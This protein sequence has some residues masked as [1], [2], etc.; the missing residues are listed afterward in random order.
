MLAFF[1]VM[2]ISILLDGRHLRVGNQLLFPILFIAYCVVSLLWSYNQTVAYRQ[3]ITQLQLILLLIFT[4]M[5]VMKNAEI[6]DYLDAVYIAGWGMVVHAI[7]RYGGL[8]NYIKIMEEGIRMGDEITNQNVFGLV[9]SNAALAAA[10]YLVFRKRKL[11]L[12][13]IAVF[14]FFALSSGSK[15][16]ALL[17]VLGILAIVAV[18]NGIKRIYKT[19]IAGV[20]VLIAASYVLQ[21]PYFETINV[22]LEEYFSGELNTSDEIRQEL[23]N[24]GVKLFQ[25]KPFFGYGLDN[26]YL[27]SP[28]GTY[29]HNNFIEVL[30]SGGV[31]GFVLYYSMYVVPLCKMFLGKFKKFAWQNKEYLMLLILVVMELVFSYGMVQLYDKNSYILLGVALASA[32]KLGLICQKETLGNPQEN[33]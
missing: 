33:K 22:R 10:Y 4:Y 26:Y 6:K 25:K 13:S 30:V 16:A 31:V 1:A 21:L 9:F 3:L 2:A 14:T 8:E 24:V 12:I 7:I 27:F 5:A 15:K 19:V 11:D 18:N 29:A 28:T 17:I 23:I 20:I 32:N